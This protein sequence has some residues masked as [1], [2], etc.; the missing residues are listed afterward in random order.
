MSLALR[1]LPKVI[2][3]CKCPKTWTYSPEKPTR[4]P[5]KGGIS[6]VFVFIPL[7]MSQYSTSTE[8]PGSINTSL[9]LQSWTC[10]FMTIGSL[11]CAS[12]PSESCLENLTT[13]GFSSFFENGFHDMCITD[14]EYLFL[15]ELVSPPPAK[16]YVM[17]LSV[18]WAIR[19]SC[20]SSMFFPFLVERF[21][22]FDSLWE[23]VIFPATPSTS[24]TYDINWP[25]W[26][27]ISISLFNWWQS[28]VWWPLKRWYE[29]N[30]SSYFPSTTLTLL[31][32]VGFN[33]ILRW[34]TSH[35][36][37]TCF[38]L[39]GVKFL[40]KLSYGLREG[41]FTNLSLNPCLWCYFLGSDPSFLDCV[42]SLAS[43]NL[44]SILLSSSLI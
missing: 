35:R 44:S 16:P 17:V 29:H 5:L 34:Y 36:I 22:E 43:Q 39:S 20:T 2:G 31:G 38:A 6:D 32:Q 37:S 14:L 33:I 3:I 42:F 9:A 7:N 12:T 25:L 27:M 40:L 41:F 10:T 11:S 1:P 18:W 24:F 21:S 13:T 15:A 4:I 30:A 26:I 8:F 28:S 19:V 23:G